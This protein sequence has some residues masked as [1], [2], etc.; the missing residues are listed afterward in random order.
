M[1]SRNS[2]LE[3]KKTQIVTT[4]S[5]NDRRSQRGRQKKSSRKALPSRLYSLAILPNEIL[6][7][8]FQEYL[9][10]DLPVWHLTAVSKKWKEIA[11]RT[12]SLWSRIDVIAISIYSPT[13]HSFVD[14]DHGTFFYKGS[15]HICFDEKSLRTIIT[16]SGATHLDICVE[17]NT[18]WLGSTDRVLPALRSLQAPSISSRIAALRLDIQCSSVVDHFPDYFHSVSLKGLQRL[19]IESLPPKWRPQLMHAVSATTR[20]LKVF[21]T[22]VYMQMESIADRVWLTVQCAILRNY[23]PATQIERILQKLSNVHEVSGI[24]RCWPSN[25]TPSTTFR[26]LRKVNLTC[27]PISFRQLQCPSLEELHVLDHYGVSDD[28]DQSPLFSEFPLLISFNLSSQ[29]PHLWLSNLSLPKLTTL[30]VHLNAPY[31]DKELLKKVGLNRFPLLKDFLLQNRGDDMTILAFLE[32]LPQVTSINLLF[33]P[34]DAYF[35]H[36]LI[37]RLAEFNKGFSLCPQL[38]RFVIGDPSCMLDKHSLTELSPMLKHMVL[39]RKTHGS[40]IKD[41]Q[42]YCSR[43]NPFDQDLVR[44]G[45]ICLPSRSYRNRGSFSSRRFGSKNW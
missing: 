10:F 40:T 17:C 34:D 26:H 32:E 37:P 29:R 12:P 19:E 24:P 8:I 39:A 44:K 27:D 21:N 14:D 1:A 23:V 30:H 38:Q 5:Q 13:Y 31:D 45:Y 16:R 33:S 3:A 41:L 20:S 18:R 35:G 42:I 6:G 28:P 2:Y 15:R 36:T 25:A 7:L 9:E 43:V 4:G 11:L 22:A